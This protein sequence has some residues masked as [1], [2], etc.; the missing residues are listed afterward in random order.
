ML[1]K[2]PKKNEERLNALFLIE[3]HF[4]KVDTMVVLVETITKIQ[5][6]KAT[7]VGPNTDR[8][9]VWHVEIL[10][11]LCEVV[12]DKHRKELENIVPLSAT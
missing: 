10:G 2:G 6:N 1:L 4:G 12:Y 7:C 3:H 9:S 5:E 8:C 11:R